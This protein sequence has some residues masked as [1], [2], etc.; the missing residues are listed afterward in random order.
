ME[1]WLSPIEDTILTQSEVSERNFIQ[2][3]QIDKQ[4]I[5][6]EYKSVSDYGQI[7][8]VENMR[9]RQREITDKGPI[10]FGVNSKQKAIGPIRK[11]PWL[12]AEVY[13]ED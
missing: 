2:R 8:D 1:P 5:L 7:E 3:V 13:V 11:P 6:V 10:E 4:W 12:E 9:G